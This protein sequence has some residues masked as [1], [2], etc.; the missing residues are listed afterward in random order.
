MSTVPQVEKQQGGAPEPYVR[1][2]RAAEFLRL[3]AR[4]ILRMARD[5]RLPG[6]SLGYGARKVWRFR[7]SELEQ[8]L[9]GDIKGRP[10]VRQ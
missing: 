5:G 3:S 1:A 2:E 6:H 10:P 9:S 4:T 7:I 8:H